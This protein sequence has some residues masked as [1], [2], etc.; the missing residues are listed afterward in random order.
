ME[1]LTK[2]KS[3]SQPATISP[4]KEVKLEKANS[5]PQQKTVVTKEQRM[6][7]FLSDVFQITNESSDKKRTFLY[8]FCGEG[9]Q[10][11]EEDTDE[12]IV[13]RLQKVKDENKFIYLINCYRR[14]ESHL[15]AKE[16]IIVVDFV[17][18]LKEQIVTYFNT[19][20]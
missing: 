10:F 13:S 1:D 7:T 15:Y 2:S 19:V 11:R 14:V 17:N 18:Q 16:K 6:H 20:L 5:T 12:I 8:E 4:S 3:Q 9:K